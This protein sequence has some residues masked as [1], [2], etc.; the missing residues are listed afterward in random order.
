M[1]A[2]ELIHSIGKLYANRIDV[3]GPDMNAAYPKVR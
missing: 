2:E 1:T 3:E